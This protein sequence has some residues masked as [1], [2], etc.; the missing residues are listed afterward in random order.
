MSPSAALAERWLQGLLL[1]AAVHAALVCSRVRA[2]ALDR[3]ELTW[4]APPGCPNERDVRASIRRMIGASEVGESVLRVEATVTRS[5]RGAF[6]LKLVV[7]GEDLMGER[8]LDGA[9]CQ[10]LAGATA[11]NLVLLLQ[12]AGAE[13]SP[14]AA[15]VT[16]A[17]AR[18]STTDGD[19]NVAG[20]GLPDAPENAEA[21]EA[22]NEPFSPARTWRFLLQV[23]SLGLSLGLLPRAS[24]G[25]A[26]SGGFVWESWRFMAGGEAWLPQ[27]LAAMDAAAAGADVQR[28]AVFVRGCRGFALA[29]FELAPC[30]HL[31]LQLLWARGEGRYVAP[32]SALAPWLAVGAGVQARLEIA[33]WLA[34]FAYVDVAWQ[35]ARPRLRIA[36]LGPVEQLGAAALSF[37]LGSEW[38]L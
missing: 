5:A 3:I 30:A 6:H 36:D 25:A 1:V 19:S 8:E 14:E 20:P 21:E 26:L 4:R 32:Q 35:G 11:V 23:P 24:L 37:S 13:R 22:H 29:G 28:A 9:S 17:D 31:G 7:Q 33:A 2:D 16:I 10:A 34:I 38:I 12:S 27:R 18:S 15:P